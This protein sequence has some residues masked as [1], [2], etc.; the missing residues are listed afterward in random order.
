MAPEHRDC[1]EAGRC[2]QRTHTAF[3]VVLTHLPS[4][5]APPATCWACSHAEQIHQIQAWGAGPWLSRPPGYRAQQGGQLLQLIRVTNVT[6]RR[7]DRGV[8]IG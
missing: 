5:E 3:Y 1:N 6:L 7:G 2:P 4:F 8:M